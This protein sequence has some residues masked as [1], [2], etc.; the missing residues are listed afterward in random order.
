MSSPN[1]NWYAHLVAQSRTNDIYTL[2]HQFLTPDW[3]PGHNYDFVVVRLSDLPEALKPVPP[4]HISKKLKPADYCFPAND[5]VL[6]HNYKL[7]DYL[8]QA[9]WAKIIEDFEDRSFIQLCYQWTSEAEYIWY[10]P[11]A[12]PFSHSNRQPEEPSETIPVTSDDY[13]LFMAYELLQSGTSRKQALQFA[14][15]GQAFLDAQQIPA[16]ANKEEAANQL[17]RLLA[18]Y[19]I[20]AM[21]YAWNNL[22]NDAAKMDALYIHEAS[23]WPRLDLQIRPYLEMLMVKGQQDYLEHL[24]ADAAFR[25]YFIAHYE[26]FVSLFVDPAY[27]LTYMGE[28]VGI[29]NRVRNTGPA[30]R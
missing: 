3:E 24:F 16:N 15:Q 14:R 4:Q 22:I 6:L 26:A 21:V 7:T 2:I 27:C 20:V 9:K 5:F 11:P 30:Y 12:Y 1:E 17:S 25:K 13:P 19:N 23:L 28:V 18:G 29:I 10:H 8:H